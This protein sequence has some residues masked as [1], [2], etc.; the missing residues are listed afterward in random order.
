VK[1]MHHLRDIRYVRVSILGALL[2]R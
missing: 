2:A 1:P